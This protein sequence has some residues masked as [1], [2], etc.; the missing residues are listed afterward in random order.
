MVYVEELKY[1]ERVRKMG[2]EAMRRPFLAKLFGMTLLACS[3]TALAQQ[4]DRLPFADG[5][6]VANPELCLLSEEARLRKYGDEVSLT[7]R[8][9]AGSRLSDGFETVCRIETVQVS[10]NTVDYRGTCET[11]GMDGPGNGSFTR[12]DDRSFEQNGTVFRKC[13]VS[14]TDLRAVQSA[15]AQR[16]Y[17]VGGADGLWGPRTARALE[18]YAREEGVAFEGALTAQLTQAI[19]AG[20]DSASEPQ[21]R[22]MARPAPGRHCFTE[23]TMRALLLD[24]RSDTSAG[25]TYD[26]MSSG[27]PHTCGMSGTAQATQSGWRYEEDLVSGPCRLEFEMSA[28]G[29]IRLLD[30]GAGCKRFYCGM[31]AEIEG[32]E[33]APAR[34]GASCGR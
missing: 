15:L 14:A 2:V 4:G 34:D 28:Q 9:I 32:A 22:T 31:R 18:R 17:D 25:F 21:R 26:S 16:G 3:G 8:E 7:Y 20:D 11:E 27:V 1:A 33:L 12:I 5:V 19:L 29:G 10:G 13:E 23:G 6:Y 30:G 24:V